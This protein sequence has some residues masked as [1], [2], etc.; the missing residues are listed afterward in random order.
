[1][2]KVAFFDTK[3]YDRLHFE[4]KAKENNIAID[5]YETKLNIASVEIAKG[6]DVVCAFVNDVLDKQVL[7][8]LYSFNIKKVV[9]RCTGYNNVDMDY[10]KSIGISVLTVPAYSPNSIAEY[11]MA[12]L[13]TI[14]RKLNHSYVR[15][16]EFNFSLSGLEGF[17]LFGKTIG[18]IGL[19]RIGSA[20]AD[21]CK[22]FGMKVLYYDR[23]VERSDINKVDLDTLLSQSDI[24][25]LHCPL[26]EETMHII[27]KD[28]IAK[29]KNKAI[30]INT[31]RGALIDSVALLGA[32]KTG[33]L[34]GAALDVYEEETDLFFN[35][36]SST[37]VQDDIIA[38]LISLPNVLVTSHQA[39]F[40]TEA[41]EQIAEKTISNI[42]S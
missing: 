7:D 9:L 25:S 3:D 30:I 4:D 35:D 39:F 34:A 27:N 38:R 13:L 36:R 8:K 22:G 26:T 37:I 32:L 29:L 33:K 41:L 2:I 6:H 14:V 11:A 28:S 16:R 42:V 15:V 40:T 18:I 19:G 12:L 1:M 17:T 31:S 21:I 5:F 23:F 20:F 24:V 10:A